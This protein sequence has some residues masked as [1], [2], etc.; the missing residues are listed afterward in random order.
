[1]ADP[2]FKIIVFEPEAGADTLIDGAFNIVFSKTVRDRFGKVA[3]RSR[4]PK[5]QAGFSVDFR[6]MSNSDADKKSSEMPPNTFRV[7]LISPRKAD[8]ANLAVAL[9]LKA[10]VAPSFSDNPFRAEIP[11]GNGLGGRGNGENFAFVQIF[12][13]RDGT[14]VLED[15]GKALLAREVAELACHEL[16]HAMGISKNQGNGLMKGDEPVSSDVDDPPP[17]QFFEEADT[18]IILKTL[19]AIATA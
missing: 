16:G 11:K 14:V 18:K 7:H 10:K 9:A 13:F 5:V 17:E 8:K 3:S 4:N 12:E 6:P 19:E 2:F 15:K 1:M